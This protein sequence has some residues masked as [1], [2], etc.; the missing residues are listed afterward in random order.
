ML[1]LIDTANLE[2][3][4]RIYD[5]LPVDGVTTNPSILKKEG[6]NPLEQL[7]KIRGFLPAGAQ[8]HVQTVSTVAEDIIKEAKFI[9]RQLGD[10]TYIKIPVFD[11]GVKAM[12]QLSKMGVNTT[13]TAIYTPMQGFMA[14]KAGVKFVAPYVNRLDNIGFDGVEVAKNIH[15][16]LVRHNLP[17]MVLAASFK[18]TQ[19]VLSLC[20]YGIG[21]ITAS[22]D[23]LEQLITHQ[24]TS[25]AIEEFNKDF[26]TVAG[27]GKTMMDLED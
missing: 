8:L 2:G 24:I 23:V 22:P 26:A 7:K 17:T 15:D 6:A 14:A 1:T 13:A 16:I 10:N 19:Q 11:E 9:L 4:K 12:K 5:I 18:N 27:E 3:I 25:L 21:S 20:E